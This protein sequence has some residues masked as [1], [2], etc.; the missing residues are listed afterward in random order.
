MVMGIPLRSDADHHLLYIP[1]CR[2]NF[3]RLNAHELTLEKPRIF[4]H[5]QTS[6]I[7]I[8]FFFATTNN[9]LN[10]YY[11]LCQR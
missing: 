2:F 8:F 11:P 7:T 9:S 4:S 5:I 1:S 3:L 6:E 10:A